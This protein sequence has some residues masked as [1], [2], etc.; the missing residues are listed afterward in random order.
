MINPRVYSAKDLQTMIKEADD[1]T[2][3]E[4]QESLKHETR[5]SVLSALAAAK[6]RMARRNEER[7]RVGALYDEM[8]RLGGDGVVLGVDEVGRGSVAGPLTVAAVALPLEPKILGLNDSK[9]LTPKRREEV[10]AN[11]AEVAT[12][13]GIAHIPPKDIDDYG[14][15]AML[16]RAMEEAIRDAGVAYDA[17]LIDGNPVH[18]SDKEVCVV[19]GDGKVASIA[20]ASIVAKVTRDHLMIDY[21][22]V[23]PGYHFAESKGYASA[24]H[25]EAIQR[26]GLSEIHRATFCENFLI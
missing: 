18:V 19:K 21:D 14:M 7:V 2:L 20:A 10:A 6:R 26:L 15:A 11:I 12:A 22:A 16:R 8:V 3:R 25:I 24:A 9:K 5:A 13:I 17:V 1:A 4:L 23:Y